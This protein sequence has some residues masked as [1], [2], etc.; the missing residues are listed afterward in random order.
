MIRYKIPEKWVRY[1][2]GLLVGE[3]AE[4][5]AAIMLLKAIPYQRRWVD[6]LQEMQLKLEIAG[7]SKIEGAD[8]SGN[9]L[10]AAMKQTAEELITRSQRQAH[11][12]TQTYRWIATIPA[13]HPLSEDLIREIHA[14]IVTGA[15]DDH[16]PAGKLRR[17]D[18]N[19][20]FGAPP[21]R[22]AGGGEECQ[23]AMKRLVHAVQHE[24]HGHDPLIQALALHYHLGAMHPFLD[25]NG[26][27]ARAVEAL[28]L[29]RAGLR[30][31]AFIAM[32]NY[33]YDEKK[34]Y[35]SSLH[36]AAIAGHD[37]TLFL[38]FALRGIAMQ[39][40]RLAHEIRM[41][42]S[43]EIFRSFAHDLF[44]RLLSPRKTLIAHRQLTI[45]EELLKR[46][47]TEFEELVR[48]LVDAYKP[49]KNA[50]KAIVR[51][52]DYLL[53]LGAVNIRLAE[54]APE[55]R[56]EFSVWLEWPSK[57]SESRIFEM[58]KTLPKAKS[59]SFLAGS[60]P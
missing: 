60:V 19:V 33:Y 54:E 56:F 15:D 10:E 41:H 45:L 1:D 12:A 37:L 57:V 49:L 29:Q 58:I 46:D 47:F 23:E 2:P 55:R 44:T 32:S 11:A 26:R 36:E 40:Q 21:H 30:D 22:G 20:S 38:K 43:K 13:D 5:K 51:D 18:Q 50:R 8:F 4:A 17:D 9:E 28:M 24:F 42:V 27:T 52:L 34:S 35:L 53:D 14:R 6:A 16:C 31:T 3:L 48:T 25:G 59:R 7:T 39:S